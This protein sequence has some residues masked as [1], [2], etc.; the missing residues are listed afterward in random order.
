[1]LLWV[2]LRWPCISLQEGRNTKINVKQQK[3]GISD[4]TEGVLTLFNILRPKS[5]HQLPEHT[6]TELMKKK[7]G[8]YHQM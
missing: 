7:K 1:M 8:D 6:P 3:L 5:E 2:P 4:N